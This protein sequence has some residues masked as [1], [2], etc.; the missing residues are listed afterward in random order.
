MASATVCP[1]ESNRMNIDKYNP[2]CIYYAHHLPL[3]L[4]DAEG[5]LCPCKR[6]LD[7]LL[8]QYVICRPF[9]KKRT[10]SLHGNE[11]MLTKLLLDALL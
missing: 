4:A 9:H 3:T 2:K 5:E 11:N 10:V 6:P 7:F 8:K 1:N